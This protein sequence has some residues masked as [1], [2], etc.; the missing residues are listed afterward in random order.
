M[1]SGGAVLDGLGLAAVLTY[2]ASLLVIG[3]LAN[4]SRGAAG[5][6]DF[7]LAGSSLGL[8]SL[9]F[10]LYAT[11]Y[12]GNT[13]LAAP[14]KAYRTGFDGLAIM[15]AVMGV[16]LVYTT[17]AVRLN[18]LAREHRFITVADFISWRFAKVV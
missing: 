4:R 18:K 17:F 11:Q 15:F 16:V 14:G 12:S 9:F 3:W 2:L 5:A 10:T 13:L 1:N 6:R 8:V 7:Y